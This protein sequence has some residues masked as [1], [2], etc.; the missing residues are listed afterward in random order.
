MLRRLLHG[1]GLLGTLDIV[2]GL[3][4]PYRIACDTPYRAIPSQGVYQEPRNGVFLGG[5]FCRI[6]CVTSKKSANCQ[7]YWA[8]QY[9]RHLERHSQERRT[10][11]YIYIFFFIY[12]C[13]VIIWA[14]FG[15]LKGYYLGQVLLKKTLFA[16]KHYKNRGFSTFLSVHKKF[17]GL[18]AGPSWPFLCCNKLGPENNPYLAQIITLQ[19]GHLFAFFFAFENVLKY[20]F[21]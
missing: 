2:A 8:Q 16:K 21:L 11:I 10:Y 17:E 6:L 3:V 1:W 5:G 20:L 14:K 13:R 4:A 18:L 15:D 7:G 12:S 19:N 9:I